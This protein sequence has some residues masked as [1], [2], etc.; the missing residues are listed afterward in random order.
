MGKEKRLTIALAFCGLALFIALGALA[1]VYQGNR[2]QGECLTAAQGQIEALESQLSQVAK[3]MT[4][5]EERLALTEA[6]KAEAEK[7][8]DYAQRHYESISRRDNPIDQYFFSDKRTV[9]TTTVEMG[10]NVAFYCE[11]WR[12]ELNHA[13]EWVK[14]V[15]KFQKDHQLLESYR[16]LIEAQADMTYDILL[17][18]GAGDYA[19][20]TEREENRQF[21][22]GTYGS[23]GSTYSAA[24]AYR[25]GTLWLLDTYCYVLDYQAHG[26]TFGFDG[27]FI[28]ERYGTENEAFPPLSQVL[29]D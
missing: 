3:E 27:D 13:V 12:Q 14:S 28:V 10:V 8:R 25:Q 26:Y 1:Y 24:E 23:V 19:P 21:I 6:E 9:G 5:M 7:E 11:A 17:L 2:E 4:Q 29:S 20:G 22:L 18:R 15:S 16:A